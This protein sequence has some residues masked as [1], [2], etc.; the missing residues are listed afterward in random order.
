MNQTQIATAST[1]VAAGGVSAQCAFHD[2]GGSQVGGKAVTT[3][4]EGV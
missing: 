4:D 2:R 3:P 1:M